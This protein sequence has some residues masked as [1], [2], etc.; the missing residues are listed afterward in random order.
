[1]VDRKEVS[2]ELKVDTGGGEELRMWERREIRM[3]W[4]GLFLFYHKP[5]LSWKEAEHLM[6]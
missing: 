2:V 6:E 4:L 5:L 1:L 3:V